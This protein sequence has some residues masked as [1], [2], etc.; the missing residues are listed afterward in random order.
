MKGVRALGFLVVV[1]CGQASTSREFSATHQA[2]VADSIRAVMTDLA[3]SVTQQGFTAWIP[4]LERSDRFVWTSDGKIEFPTADSLARFIEPFAATLKHTELSFSDVRV[5]ALAP[6][7]AQVAAT[8][9][10]MFVGQ[11]ADTTRINGVFVGVWAR[12]PDG[13]W[14]LV[15]GHTSHPTAA[16]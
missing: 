9:R 2:A 4:Y 15:S 8:Y 12:S 7:L 16:H 6:S 13:T 1:A 11:K 14:K 3:R 10:E 5:S